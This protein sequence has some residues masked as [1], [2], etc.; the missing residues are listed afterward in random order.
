MITRFQNS[1]VAQVVGITQRQVIAWTEK[2]LIQ[3]AMEASGAGTKR[4]YSY[5]NLLEFALC[6]KL[7]LRGLGIQMAKNIMAA[8]RTDGSFFS[9]A[10]DFANYH[11]RIKK[12]NREYWD[13]VISSDL[14]AQSIECYPE[15]AQKVR[16]A[17]YRDWDTGTDGILIVLPGENEQPNTKIIPFDMAYTLNLDIVK[18]RISQAGYALIVDLGAIKAEVDKK[19]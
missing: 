9:W 18:E 16:D 12:E 3:P 10:A 13:Q 6:K 4:E 5:S 7:L 19:I 17:A 8:L 15:L 11:A 14:W 1:Q 2:G